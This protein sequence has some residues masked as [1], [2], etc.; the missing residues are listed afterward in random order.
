M[1]RRSLTRRLS[2]L[3][4]LV[5]VLM[6]GAAGAWSYLQALQA[7]RDLQ[8]DVLAQVASIAAATTVK[9]AVP[10]DEIPL[11]N[12]A[13]DIDVT[14]LKRSG[15]PRSTPDGFGTGPIGGEPRRFF[16]IRNSTGSQLVVSQSVRVRDETARATA[17]ATI[18]PL[19]LLLPAL[20]LAIYLV[21][22]SVMGPVNR[23]AREV[24]AREATDLS[25]LEVEHAPSELRGFLVAL[26]AQFDRVQ[27]ALR[28]ERLFIAKAAHELRTPLTAMSLQLERAAIAP[29]SAQ[30][31]SRLA[32]LRSGVERSRH[33]IS[34]LLDLA[35]AQAGGVEHLPPQ[36]LESTARHVIGELLALADG[37]NVDLEV[38]LSDGGDQLLPVAAATSILRNLLDNAIRHNAR[39]GHVHLGSQTEGR[40]LTISVDDDGP[41]IT[42]PEEVL[43]P[44]AREAGQETTGS[45]LGLAVVAEQVRHLGGRLELLPTARFAHGTEAR[46]ILELA[47][48]T[49]E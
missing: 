9:G 42:S 4:A 23:L 18:A 6:A 27:A 37:A 38:D 49:R 19:L 17:V 28:R 45:G 41:G 10:V 15:L 2:M 36:T 26:N 43:L 24:N 33:L 31:R 14:S 22:R 8:D 13:S 25:P 5:I 40:T 48:G 32:E 3:V 35:H 20:I 39:G 44:F 16:V 34:Q 47:Q 46:V 7:A 29:D 30:L 11:T 21:V 1:G 12:S